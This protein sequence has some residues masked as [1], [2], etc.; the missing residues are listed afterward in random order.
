MGNWCIQAVVALAALLAAGC[1]FPRDA[2]GTIERV[3]SQKMLR[4]GFSERPPWVEVDHGRPVGIEPRLIEAFAAEIGARPD[5]VAGSESSLIEALRERRIDLMI[6]GYDR[7]SPWV[8][9]AAAT[10]PYLR[11]AVIVAAPHGSASA[12]PSGF[13]GALQGKTVAHHALRPDLAALIAPMGATPEPAA[14][15][16]GRLAVVYDFQAQG[17]GLEPTGIVLRTTQRVLLAPPGESRLLFELDRF[18]ARAGPGAAAAS[19]KPKGS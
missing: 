2:G 8:D 7:S 1:E 18:L 9:R 17:L 15:L 19:D 12:S 5:W 11:S 10:E 13:Q 3:R 6:G 16:G 14:D 4:V